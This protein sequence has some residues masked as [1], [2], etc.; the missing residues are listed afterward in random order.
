MNFI[1]DIFILLDTVTEVVNK[2]K[3]ILYEIDILSCTYFL[4]Y[5]KIT[6]IFF[7]FFSLQGYVSSIVKISDSMVLCAAE[8]P[9]ESLCKVKD[10][11]IVPGSLTSTIKGRGGGNILFIRMKGCSIDV[12][13]CMN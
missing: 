6:I 5:A 10:T 1:H 3:G 2:H 4:Y 12:V 13:I 11:F 8:L 7:F 9:L